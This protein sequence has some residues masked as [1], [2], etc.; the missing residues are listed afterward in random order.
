MKR[1]SFQKQRPLLGGRQPTLCVLSKE[2]IADFANKHI[3]E[4]TQWERNDP[5]HSGKKPPWA[6]HCP[7]NPTD[8]S[9]AD[10]CVVVREQ[11][12]G[13]EL[14]PAIRREQFAGGLTLQR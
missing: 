11:H 14:L 9:A 7:E 5:K 13:G 8:G 1:E 10:P 12:N 2:P 6:A 3:A 4:I